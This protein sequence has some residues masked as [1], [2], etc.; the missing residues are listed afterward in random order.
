[1]FFGWPYTDLH[2]LN[3]DWILNLCKDI[4]TILDNPQEYFNKY[5]SENINQFLPVAMYIPETMT[6]RLQAGNIE[7]DKATHYYSTK[8]ETIT[9]TDGAVEKPITLLEGR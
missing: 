5:I 9:V 4:K 2:S 3:L 8:T 7:P 6:I 1:M